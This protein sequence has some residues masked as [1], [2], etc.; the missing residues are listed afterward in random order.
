MLLALRHWLR[1]EW[2]YLVHD[3]LE[4]VWTING[5][6]NEDDVGLGVGERPQ[7]VVLLLSGS[8]PESKLDHLACRRVWCVGDVVLK[9]GGY[10]FL[11]LLAWPTLEPRHATYLW[12]VAGAVADQQTCLAAS[13]VTDHHQLL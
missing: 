10:I 4:R 2:S 8:V 5:E 11:R 12:K 3:I 6:A 1:K 9:D 7:S 13:T